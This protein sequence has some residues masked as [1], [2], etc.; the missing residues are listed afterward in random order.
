MAL[1]GHAAKVT[2][3]SDNV[4]FTEVD[5]IMN[6]DWGPSADLIETTDFKDTTAAK[7]RIHG[8]HDLQVT[9][10]GQYESG[11]APQALIRTSF[12]SGATLYVQFL[13]DGT[14]G[15][16]CATIVQDF[17]LN[18]TV[19]GAVE[20]SATLVGNGAISTV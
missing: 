11:D 18:A 3:S 20:F 10:S 8:L 6:I 9:V 19:E 5:G 12:T 14:N 15:F 13:P 1:A 4:T 2:T 17:K 16:K 7:S